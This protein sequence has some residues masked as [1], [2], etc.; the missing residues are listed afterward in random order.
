MTSRP[1]DLPQIPSGVLLVTAP[2]GQTREYPLTGQGVVIGRAQECDVVVE[3]PSVSR[4]H[5][6]L[7]VHEGR[8]GLEDLESLNATLLGGRPVTQASLPEVAV[9]AIGRT[10]LEL[11]AGPSPGAHA[12]PGQEG[13]QEGSTL[14]RDQATVTRPLLSSPS[15]LPRLIMTSGQSPGAEWVLT[16]GENTVTIGRGTPCAV[17]LNDPA[18]SRLHAVLT[19][20]R[21]Q[22]RL[23][24]RSGHGTEVNGR[25]VR[26]KRLAP[27]DCIQIGTSQFRYAGPARRRSRV[28][29]GL[30]L[31]LGLAAGLTAFLWRGQPMTHVAGEPS[32]DLFI[33]QHYEEGLRH[34]RGR[35]WAAAQAEFDYVLALD[36]AHEEARHYRDRASRLAHA[37]LAVEAARRRLAEGAL[38]DAQRAIEDV[39]RHEPTFAEALEVQGA[40]TKAV[41]ARGAKAR[42]FRQAEDAFERGALDEATT[43]LR[44]IQPT[45]GQYQA[46]QAYL[47]ER[48]PL[49]AVALR[50]LEAGLEKYRAGDV[51]PAMVQ[52]DQAQALDPAFRGTREA[53]QHVGRVL[54]RYRALQRAE[55]TPERW[56]L[57]MA[58]QRL[59]ALEH[60]RNTV[61]VQHAMRRKRELEP[62]LEAMVREAFDDAGRAEAAGDLPRAIP[63]YLAVLEIRPDDVRARQALT[64]LRPAMDQEA[65]RLYDEAYVLQ[66]REPRRAREQWQLVL[67]L[68]PIDHPYH[69]KAQARLER[70]I[71]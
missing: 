62:G 9:I 19:V 20:R 30:A 44:Q 52:L 53:R 43:S 66:D 4:R 25:R 71:P 28:W 69:Q 64:R 12:G 10:T 57:W 46:A 17:L 59:L 11:R 39:L 32:K 2:G 6:R 31:G 58:L 50:H 36:Q 60:D 63:P 27:G 51:G 13:S 1:N 42:L 48:L 54:T 3:D 40:V 55:G 61:Y 26:A 22:A 16:P 67:E 18:V 35:Q 70:S 37:A 56:R 68:T 65:R 15:R 33:S 5:A 47:K 49:R 14:T 23:V 41:E 8:Y 45:D 34:F 29:V 7:V 38:D 21:G 24:D